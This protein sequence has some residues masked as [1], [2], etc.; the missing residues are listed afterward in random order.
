[1]T[2]RKTIPLTV[3]TFVGKVMSLFFNMLSRF[4]IALLYMIIFF[5]AEDTEAL[6]SQQKQHLDLTVTPYCQIQTEIEESRENH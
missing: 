6:H 3:W 5:A 4:I 1:M 2:N